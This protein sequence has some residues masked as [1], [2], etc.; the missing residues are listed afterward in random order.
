[1]NP[2]P[3]TLKAL[4]AVSG[5]VCAFPSC[6]APIYDTLHGKL[7]GEA[8]H[9]KAQRPNGPRY[10]PN[11]T[12]T[13]RNGYDNLVY[14]CSPHHT[15]IDDP[16][17]LHEY[18]VDVLRGYKTDHESK[19]YNTI[20]TED[21]LTR[22]VRKVLDLQQETSA[23]PAPT[24]AVIVESFLER[25]GNDVGIDTY[26][27]RIKLRNDGQSTVRNYR[28]EVEIPWDHFTSRSIYEAEVKEHTRGKVRLF[29]FTEKGHP[30]FTLYPGDTSH[31]LS[32]LEYTVSFQQYRTIKT[33]A[34]KVILYSGDTLLSSRDYPLTNYL[35]DERLDHIL[36]M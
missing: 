24:V 29:R 28:I 27:F 8:C 11:Q 13:E 33:E 2:S 26:D 30:G 34:I 5:N 19:N 3:A 21:V 36:G 14:M 17:K 4:A 18:T 25:A 31:T 22:L 16:V 7:V 6:I 23:A 35:S 15:V 20:L 10:D 32:K 9:I 12:D 1:M